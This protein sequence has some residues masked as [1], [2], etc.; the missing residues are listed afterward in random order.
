MSKWLQKG[1]GCCAD[2]AA[3]VWCVHAH[4]VA[5][6]LPT[7]VL[8]S[9]VCSHTAHISPAPLTRHC[10]LPT[11]HCLLSTSHCPL[12]TSYSALLTAHS[13]L[14][15]QHCSLPTQGKSHLA[16]APVSHK[17]HFDAKRLKR[18][19]LCRIGS[20]CRCN[21]GLFAPDGA[22]KMQKGCTQSLF[23]SKGRVEVEHHYR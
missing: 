9:A 2:L 4:S 15:T 20:V 10:L 11:H 23:Q 6:S 17:D 3:N 1:S 12:S 22:N 21:S 18:H 13:S 8:I 5:G 19:S 7:K 16:G 14:P